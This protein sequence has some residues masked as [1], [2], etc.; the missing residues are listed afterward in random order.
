MRRAAVPA[1]PERVGHVRAPV[2]AAAADPRQAARPAAGDRRRAGDRH[3]QGAGRPLRELPRVRGRAAGRAV[4]ADIRRAGGCRDIRSPRSP[5]PGSAGWKPAGV[6]RKPGCGGAALRPSRPAYGSPTRRRADRAGGRAP[7]PG[8][9]GLGSR[10]RAGRRSA[11]G[12]ARGRGQRRPAVVALAGPVAVIV[13]SRWPCSPP[14]ALLARAR[15]RRPWLRAGPHRLTLPGLHDSDGKA[16]QP[17][18][19][20]HRDD[21]A[22]RRTLRR[23]GDGQRLHIRHTGNAVAAAAQR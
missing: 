15:E 5:I 2:R 8:R 23:G 1:G 17:D 22:Q 11:P 10:G 3:G 12:A 19:H 16:P 7:A 21:A 6:A 13:A 4:G 14:A 9:P 20:Q 18:R